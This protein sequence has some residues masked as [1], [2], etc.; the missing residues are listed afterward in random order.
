MPLLA[1]SKGISILKF[2]DPLRCYTAGGYL[3]I[4]PHGSV[5]MGEE[6]D[7]ARL[8][9]GNCSRFYSSKIAGS[10]ITRRKSLQFT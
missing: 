3:D 6:I 8:A 4:P 5:F 7:R 9:G 1:D 10:R 2:F